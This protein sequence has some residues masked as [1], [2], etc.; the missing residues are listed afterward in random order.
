MNHLVLSSLLFIASTASWA[1]TLED[2]AKIQ[3]IVSETILKN[4]KV[5]EAGVGIAVFNRNEVVFQKGFGLRDRTSKKEVTLNTAFAIASTTKAFTSLSLK[6]LENEG[7]LKLND[8]V[9]SHLP[10]FKLSIE[11]IAE[12][13][14]LEDLLSHQTGLPRHDLMWFFA[15]FETKENYRRLQYLSFPE[16][17]AEEIFR[18]EMVYNNFMYMVAGM[19]IEEVA[20]ESYG[21]FVSKNILKPLNMNETT[22]TV[23]YG[24][25]DLATPYYGEEAVTHYNAINIAAAGSLYSTV[26]DM[27][28]WI[29][30]FM[31]NKWDNQEDL[32][33]ARIHLDN[34][35]PSLDYGYA[36][37]WV[38]NTMNKPDSW[39]FHNGSLPGFSSFV[40]FSP[41]LDIGF[42]ILE[43]Q[44]SSSLGDLLATELLKYALSKKP[45]EKSGWKKKRN[46]QLFNPEAN[47]FPLSAK[48]IQAPLKMNAKLFENPGYGILETFAT[49]DGKQFTNYY[50]HV[51]EIKPMTHDYF[52]FLADMVFGAEHFEFPLKI[53]EDSIYAPFQSDVPLIEFKF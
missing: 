27:T 35:N 49:S 32:F 43:N 22:I 41:K 15:D 45:Q 44:N 29:Q 14:T 46:L 47:S 19:V 31:Q 8:R 21:D 10:D 38:T 5:Q 7:K 9:R 52:N 12:Q 3:A 11:S 33:K 53:N 40:L 39:Y 25:E 13:A 36:L 42:V 6:I 37:G 28:K 48:D 20:S 17:N 4:Q 26:Q 18:K 23:P 34:E 16:K 30:S 50:G 51:W 2:Q 24:R 1:V